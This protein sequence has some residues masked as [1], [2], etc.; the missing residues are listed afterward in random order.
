M[1]CS[2]PPIAVFGGKHDDDPSRMVRYPV[3]EAPARSARPR[4]LFALAWPEATPAVVFIGDLF[5]RA[6]RTL[7]APIVLVTIAAGITSLADP[8]RLVLPFDR[9]L[10]MMRIVPSASANLTVATTVARWEGELDEA[11]HR[12]PGYATPAV[13]VGTECRA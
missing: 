13:T 11:D 9:L 1:A 8:K 12:A 5:V 3:V 10:D 6:I 7:V 4:L 2:C